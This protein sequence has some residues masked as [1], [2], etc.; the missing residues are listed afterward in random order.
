MKNSP[1]FCERVDVINNSD[2]AILTLAAIDEKL[3]VKYMVVNLA[4]F[5]VE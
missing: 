1:E 4:I 2:M 3:W 5:Q